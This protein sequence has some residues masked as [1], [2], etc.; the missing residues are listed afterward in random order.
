MST[1]QSDLEQF[2]SPKRPP[3]GGLEECDRPRC[4][5]ETEY[6]GNCDNPIIP[7]MDVCHKHLEHSSAFDDVDETD[8]QP[9]WERS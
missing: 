5:F 2:D 3:K 6:H 4:G 1:R 8:D 7:G 9:V